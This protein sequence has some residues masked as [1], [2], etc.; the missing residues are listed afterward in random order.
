M[1]FGW[2]VASQ[3]ISHSRIVDQ[4]FNFIVMAQQAVWLDRIPSVMFLPILPFDEQLHWN[5]QGYKC[6][7][8][9]S[10]E[11][12]Y[13]SIGATGWTDDGELPADHQDVQTALEAFGQVFWH[14]VQ[15]MSTQ[16]PPEEGE[17]AKRSEC[18]KVREFFATCAN[19]VVPCWSSSKIEQALKAGK[20]F[21]VVEFEGCNPPLPGCKAT[22]KYS[23]HPAPLPML[24]HIR[25]SNTWVHQLNILGYF[26]HE[27][28]QLIEKGVGAFLF[29]ACLDMKDLT[30]HECKRCFDIKQEQESYRD[31]DVEEETS[32]PRKDEGPANSSSSGSPASHTS[33]GAASTSTQDTQ[34][35]DHICKKET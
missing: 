1:L 19:I 27:G 17:P 22:D 31:E 12:V 32:T 8:L 6:I 25:T 13:R 15:V 10:H 11:D 16:S 34:V 24:L 21:R 18:Q 23:K 9:A 28:K 33:A 7:V 2:V 3:L 26:I 35:S 30:E 20:V 4:L 5:G 29:M 14:Y